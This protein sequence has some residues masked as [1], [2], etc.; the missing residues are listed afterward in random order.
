MRREAAA[1]AEPGG[2]NTDAA[3]N[4]DKDEAK[5]AVHM[6]LIVF[7]D[8]GHQLVFEYCCGAR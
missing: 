8:A 1:A 5:R 4:H 3:A 6:L 7:G 2:S